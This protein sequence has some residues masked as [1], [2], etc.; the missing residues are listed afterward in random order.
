MYV[1]CL[2]DWELFNRC[3]AS[4]KNQDLSLCAHLSEVGR[5]ET[6]NFFQSHPKHSDRKLI[7]M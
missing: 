7:D 6:L 2:F 1:M 3:A 5:K 4:P